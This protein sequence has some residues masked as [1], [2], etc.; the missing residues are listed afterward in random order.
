MADGVDV[1]V[2]AGDGFTPTPALSHAILTYNRGRSDGPRRR[3]R[4]DA[5]RTT[6]PRTAASSTTR[7]TAARPTP[8]SRAGSRTRPTGSSRR[9]STISP[10]IPSSGRAR[11]PGRTT[12][13]ASTSATSAR[14]ST[15]RRSAASGLRLGVDPLGG[16]S[17][18][19]WA[20]IGERYGLDLTVVNQAVDPTFRFMTVDWDGRIRMDPSSPY[21]MAGLVALRDRFDLAL[22]N[23][24]DADRHGIV[25][26]AAG[27]LNPNHFLSAAIA[28]L[29]GG[30]RDWGRDVAVG[31]TLVSSRDDR[32]R[33]GRPRPAAA[34]G[35]GRLQVVRRRPDRRLDR[36]R[37]RG[38]RRR[39][40]P[41]PR[42][43]DLDHRQ[44]RDHRLPAGRRD[45]RPHRPRPGRRLRAS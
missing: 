31:K 30:A 32:P 11:R 20:A 24:A 16:A 8:T 22:G 10:A 28:Y 36:V 45:D 43:H 35:P 1:L 3:H 37:R 15:W 9:A 23:D 6:R 12:S 19:Y 33:R 13:W 44:G 38:E 7:P 18:A 26:P 39:L 41:A 42:R 27:L 25:T 17:V 4:R 5:R 40:V 14:S 34:R 29:F 21:A 2:D